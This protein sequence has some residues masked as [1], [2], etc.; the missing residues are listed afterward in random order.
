MTKPIYEI[1]G[2]SKRCG[3]VQA[4]SP[5]GL[6]YRRRRS[7]GTSRRQWRWQV[8]PDQADVGNCPP[9]RWRGSSRRRPAIVKSRRDSEHIGIETIYQD[10]ALVDTMSIVHNIFMGREINNS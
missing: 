3:K 7:G 1:R 10:T 9:G 2:V 5:P 8:H 6:P 4:L